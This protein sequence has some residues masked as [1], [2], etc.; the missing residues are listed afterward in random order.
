MPRDRD[1]SRSRLDFRDETKN[2]SRL[3]FTR[4]DETNMSRDETESS[5]LSSLE[6]LIDIYNT[7]HPPEYRFM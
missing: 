3:E 2:E 4:R 6:N 5:R 7:L 1:Q